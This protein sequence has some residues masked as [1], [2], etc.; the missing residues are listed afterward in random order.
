LAEPL[1]SFSARSPSMPVAVA[2]ARKPKLILPPSTEASQPPPVAMPP[3]KGVGSGDGSTR[4][5]QSMIVA[6]VAGGESAAVFAEV[7]VFG[8][9]SWDSHTSLSADSAGSA[10]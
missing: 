3:M 9:Q 7:S 1:L 10:R 5:S 2:S 8:A 6:W 4:L